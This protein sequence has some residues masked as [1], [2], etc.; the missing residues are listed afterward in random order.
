MRELR[1]RDTALPRRALRACRGTIHSVATSLEN[2]IDSV[3][4][5]LQAIEDQSDAKVKAV[6]D[7]A[8]RRSVKKVLDMAGRSVRA[9]LKPAFMP[10]RLEAVSDFMFRGTWPE[11]SSELEEGILLSSGYV[12]ES[13]R[14]ERLQHWPPPQPF[15]GAEGPWRSLPPRPLEWLRAKILYS[16][17]PADA[18]KFKHLQDPM[19]LF[20]VLLKMTPYCGVNV[21]F[22][23]LLFALIERSDEGQLV[24][25]VLSFKS[26][27]FLSGLFTASSLCFNLWSCLEKEALGYSDVE[28][29][30][31]RDQAPGQAWYF[32]LQLALELG[33]VVLL[34]LAG[35]MLAGGA[36]YG[37]SEE[38]FA[39]EAVRV[40]V[41][42]ADKARRQR[43]AAVAEAN[44]LNAEQELHHRAEAENEFAAKHM[45]ALKAPSAV[46]F[47]EGSGHATR[48]TSPSRR[49]GSGLAPVRRCAAALCFW[50]SGYAKVDD[51]HAEHGPPPS[52]EAFGRGTTQDVID[53]T[54]PG[55]AERRV[56]IR[57]ALHSARLRYGVQR[58]H[59]G[60]LPYFI[61]YDL[62]VISMLLLWLLIHIMWLHARGSPAWLSWTAAYYTKLGWG[63]MSAPFVVFNLPVFGQ[64]L[65]QAK[66]TGY[67]QTGLLVR[68]LTNDLMKKK[69]IIEEQEALIER[70]GAPSASPDGERAAI[71]VQKIYRGNASRRRRW[72]RHGVSL[73]TPVGLFVPAVTIEQWFK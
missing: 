27:Q 37:G 26:F 62:A 65:H 57:R 18:N 21:I 69:T 59:G 12:G 63:I 56:A 41:H 71:S 31:C 47:D 19:A 39:L 70:G 35:M 43:E 68:R 25:Y 44:R 22:F 11:I 72:M 17:L 67:D 73:L 61:L 9:M 14:K 34:L 46:S 7:N 64:A 40:R 24:T 53:S 33:R 29:L 23:I 49:A 15:W 10:K 55:T 32:G 1:Q 16:L 28:E 20:I 51:E 5:R 13:L 2:A 50:G 30:T 8:M 3:D 36:T 38:L 58:R 42:T 4:D 48:A 54:E 66:S 60:Y 52:L 6:L 45:W